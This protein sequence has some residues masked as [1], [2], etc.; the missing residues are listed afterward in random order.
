MARAVYLKLAWSTLKKNGRVTLP[1]LIGSVFLCA[2][3]YSIISLAI[4]PDLGST[5]GG[6]TMVQMMG[7]GTVVTKIFSIALFLYLN[8]ILIRFRRQEQGLFTVLGMGKGH[9][10][11][12]LLYQML[13][14]LAATLFLG[15]PLGIV[16]DKVMYLLAARILGVEVPLGFTI[17]LEAVQDV[18]LW[19]VIVYAVLIGWSAW[20]VFRSSPLDLLKGE[21]QAETEPK[22]R[23]FLAAAG[24]ICL[25]VGYGMALSITDPLKALLLFFIAV[26]FVIAGT[27]LLFMFGSVTVMKMLQKN[28]R[29]YYKTNHFISVSLMKFRIRQNAASLASIAI[30]STSVLVA[31]SASL[32]LFYS[33]ETVINNQFP[34][35]MMVSCF[36]ELPSDSDAVQQAV[37]DGIEQSGLAQPSILSWR[38]SSS[39]GYV[40]DNAYSSEPQNTPG[41]S[42]FML[43]LIDAADYNALN[44]QSLQI[45]GNEIYGT[46]NAWKDGQTVSINGNEMVYRQSPSAIEKMGDVVSFAENSIYPSALCVVSSV[47]QMSKALPSSSIKGVT[48]F[49]LKPGVYDRFISEMDPAEL[50]EVGL[51]AQQEATMNI[52]AV[53]NSGIASA[54][55]QNDIHYTEKYGGEPSQFFSVSSKEDTRTQVISMFASLLFI[56]IYVA[57]MFSLAVVLIMYFKQI[58][59]GTE[60]RKRFAILQNAGLEAKQIRRIINDQVLMLFFLPLGTAALHLA[61]AFPMISRMLMA[62]SMGSMGFGQDLFLIVTLATFGIFALIYI[63][64][65]RLT[66]SVYY[67]IVKGA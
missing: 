1:Y 24:V 14:L 6:L 47:D 35:E 60:D 16:V 66:S 23:W 40:S 57:L 13:M 43:V 45:E 2:L 9:L 36:G 49:D 21:K 37:K 22:N 5:F 56:G 30:L 25:A 28:K 34:R 20:R 59:E 64:I 42:N 51:T 48:A 27:Y 44:G 29:Y 26:L 4:N 52:A 46:V 55:Q 65:Y 58:T 3:L 38:Q 54:L 61:F 8:G 18:S 10:F 7:F 33:S 39:A 12:I 15:I 67:S 41:W 11:R 19:I 50:K 32:S 62:V 53:I 17:S 31:L 63:V